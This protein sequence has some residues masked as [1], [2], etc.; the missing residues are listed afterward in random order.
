MANMY[1]INVVL[2]LASIIFG[3]WTAAG[4]LN[5]KFNH[6]VRNEHPNDLDNNWWVV[7][8]VVVGAGFVLAGY[9]MGWTA[10][11]IGLWIRFYN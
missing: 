11:V 10:V 8:L 6:L 9:E 5:P 7:L 3:L 1:L 4:L 2:A